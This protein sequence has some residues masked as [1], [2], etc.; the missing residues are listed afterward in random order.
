MTGIELFDAVVCGDLD[1]HRESVSQTTH[2]PV[3]V[4]A[5]RTLY[6]GPGVWSTNPDTIAEAS[7]WT[8][9]TRAQPVTLEELDGKD[10]TAF[11]I[12]ALKTGASV[13]AIASQSSDTLAVQTVV[14]AAS[15]QMGQSLN[16]SVTAHDNAV[17]RAT[18]QISQ[19]ARHVQESLTDQIQRLVGGENPELMER[20]RP[21]LEGVGSNLQ[22][23]VTEGMAAAHAALVE[24]SE[25][26]HKELADLVVSVR[27]EV[28]V[29]VAEDTAASQ[30]IDGLKGATTIK[31]LDYEADMD[32]LCTELAAQMG[33]EYQSVGQFAG[34]LARNKKGDGVFNIA[35]GV[36]R[37]VLEYHDGSSKEWGSY[38]AEAERN[39][40][41][42]AALGVVRSIDDNEGRLL[43]VIGPKRIILAFD[44]ADGD[45]ELLRTVLLLM[46]TLAMTSSGQFSTSQISTANESIR[47]AMSILES[48]ED[49]KRSASAM[50]GHVDKIEQ[51]ITKVIS[52]VNRELHRAVDALA[53]VDPEPVAESEDEA[54][55][56]DEPD[57]TSDAGQDG[58]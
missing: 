46:R 58:S 10:L 42:S 5:D 44:P 43:R 30:A 27:Q 39:R 53:G 54:T 28:A 12:A 19:A 37:F 4:H 11:V 9:G 55:S 13:L 3:Y 48:L 22:T 35:G 7:R 31:G 36:A 38:L 20:L 17:Q 50:R 6:V 34:R 51:T 24:D 8:T 29:K 40:G 57:S 41:A 49:A 1:M 15:E 21:L 25:R 26:R 47:E 33:D 52:S 45:V 32:T 18:E 2:H 14:K 16:Q 23:Q 56:G